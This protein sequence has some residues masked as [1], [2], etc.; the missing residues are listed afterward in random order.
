MDGLTGKKVVM[1]IA[2][3][4]FRDEELLMPK[5]ILEEKGVQVF[6]ASKGTKQAYGMIEAKVNVDLD[7][8]EIKVEDFDGIV[9]VGGTGAR[10]YFNDLQALNLV[11]K[12][13]NHGK[14][15]GAICIAP[16]ILANAGILRGVRC[17]AFSTERSV[18]KKE[19]AAFINNSVV[20]DGK[21]ITAQGPMAATAFG[22]Q[23][24]LALTF[25]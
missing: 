6:I 19:G 5:K 12:A 3:Q 4:Q 13:V 18:L 1:V 20:K 21:I 8:G 22:Q 10:L 15:V 9:F 24:A 2:P 17:T 14:I 25:S 7:V 11:K 16:T 23:L